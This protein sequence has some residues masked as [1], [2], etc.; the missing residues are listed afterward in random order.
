MHLLRNQRSLHCSMRGKEFPPPSSTD[1]DIAVD[2]AVDP[3]S[4]SNRRVGF[5]ER[6]GGPLRVVSGFLLW[7]A[8]G[9]VPAGVA[10]GRRAQHGGGVRGMRQ[11]MGTS[12]WAKS[13]C[14]PIVPKKKRADWGTHLGPT[15]HGRV[16]NGRHLPSRAISGPPS[17][18]LP[19][20]ARA[21]NKVPTRTGSVPILPSHAAPAPAVN[22]KNV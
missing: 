19:Y 9:R 2:V 14:G 22:G 17:G 13:R 8:S 1:T 15:E 7:T 11:V 3:R 10:A 20:G 4:G 5:S 6:K 18:A 16:H 21:K 12:Q